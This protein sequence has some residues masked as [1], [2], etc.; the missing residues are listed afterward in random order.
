MKSNFSVKKI[1]DLVVFENNKRIPL[2]ELDRKKRSGIYPYYGASGIIDYID[3]YIFDGVYLLIS[4][5]GEN[6]KTR[7][8]PVAFKASGKFW[9]N[10]HAHILSEKEEGIL[11][12]IQYYFSQ[13]S[14]SP[15]I[16]GAAQPKLS[17]KNLEIIEVN[18]PE[19][20]TRTKINYI[21][22]SITKKIELN[23][24]I[25]QTLE[26]IAQA[27]FKSWFV[28]FDPVHAKANEKS[29]D[30]YD[31]IAKEL[32]ISREILDLFPSEFEETELGL[33]PKG[34]KINCLSNFITVIKGK[35]YKS[36]ELQP[37][38]TALVTLKSFLRGGGY[39]LDGLKQY[40]GKYN[41][42]QE[43]KPGELIIAYTD[44]TQN[45]DVIGK[46]AIVIEDKNIETLIASLDVGIVRIIKGHFSIG[47]LFYYFK[48]EL[49]QNYILGYTSGTTVLHLSKNWIENHSILTPPLN[50]IERFDKFCRNVFEQLNENI[51]ET[52]TLDDIKT[53]LLPKLLSGEIDVSN[54]NLEPE[55]D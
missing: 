12:Y 1:K 4:E 26:S 40:N 20:K 19:K 9:V 38:S 22:N 27:M 54:L 15:Y 41:S 31:A 35:S 24:K 29:V 11:D 2:K 52:N 49:F 44:V 46:P 17:K 47:Y 28:D 43:V 36:S 18:L 6:L 7:K 30:D 32:G 14:L 50:I 48:T 53:L 23:K 33:I 5:D 39:R 34:W 8:T 51:Q 10:N 13:L 45:A 21:L 3:N 55:N 37:S 16:T 42:E 25:N